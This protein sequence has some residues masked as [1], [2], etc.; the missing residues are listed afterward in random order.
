VYTFPTQCTP[1]LLHVLDR[2]NVNVVLIP[3][4]CTDRLQPLDLTV[5]KTAKDLLCRKQVCVQL[6]GA[7]NKPVDHPQ[8]LEWIKSL[9]KYILD[10]PSIVKNG[11]KAAGILK[12][13]LYVVM[14]Y[15][16]YTHGYTS[17][18]T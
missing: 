6:D 9:Y 10:N 2:Y 11:F 5:N 17:H 3:A 15:S 12:L 7:Q 8:A 13:L 1:P 16:H 14:M 4:K 18:F